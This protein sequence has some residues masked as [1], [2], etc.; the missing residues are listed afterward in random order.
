MEEVYDYSRHRYC[1]AIDLGYD[2]ITS[3]SIPIHD[4]SRAEERYE[5]KYRTSILY[6]NTTRNIIARGYKV[7]EANEDLEGLQEGVIYV[8][9][10]FSELNDIYSKS[11]QQSFDNMALYAVLYEEAIDL[12]QRIRVMFSE[13]TDAYIIP[14]C[15]KIKASGSAYYMY[16]RFTR[17]AKRNLVPQFLKQ[18][19][20]V[21]P[22]GLKELRLSL[23]ACVEKHCDT[24]L[25]SE[26]IDNMLEKLSQKYNGFK[27][28]VRV[29]GIEIENTSSAEKFLRNEVDKLFAGM[30]NTVPRPLNIF[31][32]IDCWS[33]KYLEELRESYPLMKFLGVHWKFGLFDD[34]ARRDAA[35]QLLKNR[36]EEFNV[37]RNPII[38]PNETTIEKP[39][40]CLKPIIFINIG[41]LTR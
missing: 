9:N 30:S 14:T 22:F 25:S 16:N 29:N 17:L 32:T 11:K 19:H 15:F 7:D 2:M 35:I 33:R 28:F 38:L 31:Y 20:F 24:T 37:R 8:R 4:L 1:I 26:S 23:I 13:I 18:A 41:K 3:Q 12:L 27:D 21:I 34:R 39:K 36:M 6:D 5:K 10:I 40:S